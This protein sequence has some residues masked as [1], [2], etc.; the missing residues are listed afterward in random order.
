MNGYG[1][2]DYFG[3]TTDLFTSDKLLGLLASPS[4]DWVIG[5]TLGH[6]ISYDSRALVS[7]FLMLYF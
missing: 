7:N 1:K 6:M 4:F 3:C 5:R 2:E